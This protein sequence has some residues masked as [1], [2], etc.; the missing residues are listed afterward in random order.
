MTG[1]LIRKFG[2]RHTEKR[3]SEDIGRRRPSTSQ[4][5][6]PPKKPTLPTPDLRLLTS[7]IV[8]K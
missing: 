8:R 6:R 7:R 2:H 3:P 1:V 5:E 4:G